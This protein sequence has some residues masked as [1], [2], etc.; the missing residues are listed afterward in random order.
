MVTGDAKSISAV[1]DVTGLVTV[2]GNLGTLASKYGG[3]LTD[4]DVTGDAKSVKA[5]TDIGANALST[6]NVGGMLTSMKASGEIVAGINVTGYAGK[7]YAVDD[8][9]GNLTALSFGTV[10][11]RQEITGDVTTTGDITTGGARTISG[12][13]GISGDVTVGGS[14]RSLKS[15]YGDIAGLVDVTGI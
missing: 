1:Q 10:S 11:S 13:Y 12:S 2:G 3:I 6:F 5:G 8:I 7:I 14:L 9:S 15:S 4:V